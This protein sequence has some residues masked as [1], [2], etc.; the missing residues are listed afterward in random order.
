M[1]QENNN[2]IW[3]DRRNPD[4]SD[5]NMTTTKQ[6]S[7]IQPNRCYSFTLGIPVLQRMFPEYNRTRFIQK[8]Y[9]GIKSTFLNGIWL[10]KT[11]GDMYSENV[12]LFGEEKDVSGGASG[13]RET[14]NENISTES[15]DKT[16]NNSIDIENIVK[17]TTANE[18]EPVENNI[19]GENGVMYCSSNIYEL[20][21]VMANKE[22]LA[23][24]NCELITMDD[25]FTLN[26]NQKMHYMEMEIG[27]NYVKDYIMN[28]DLGG[29]VYLEYHSL[30]H[31]HFN[32]YPTNGGY[33]ILGHLVSR[34]TFELTAFQ[35]P[36]NTGIY[37]PPSVIHNDCFLTGNYF[38][39]YDIAPIYSTVLL[40]QR[41]T[42]KLV[43][44]IIHPPVDLRLDELD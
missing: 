38:V 23:H 17:Y 24:Y 42:K 22:N 33:I 21:A 32:P 1:N 15:D 2:R 14:M 41:K 39:M 25:I 30:P 8:N 6:I 27:K 20:Q 31:F 4:I 43:N 11:L 9:P 26:T 13:E 5:S 37:I 34:N 7:L 28:P 18:N 36:Y 3:I 16:E 29:G 35:I 12:I 44:F 10:D 40:K 19:L